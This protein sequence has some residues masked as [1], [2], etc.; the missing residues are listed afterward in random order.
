MVLLQQAQS[1]VVIFKPA[2]V[3]SQFCFNS[4]DDLR[5]ARINGLQ[6]FPQTFDFRCQ[7]RERNL[8]SQERPERGTHHGQDTEYDL[9]DRDIRYLGY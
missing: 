6:P 2:V 4:A 7:G 9:H 8:G 3:F 5:V 1:L